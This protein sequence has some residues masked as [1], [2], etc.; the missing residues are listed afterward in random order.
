M[1]ASAFTDQMF[2]PSNSPVSA[3][4]FA[5]LT[6]SASCGHFFAQIPQ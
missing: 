5:R 4:F 6:V 3:F 2:S 1:Q